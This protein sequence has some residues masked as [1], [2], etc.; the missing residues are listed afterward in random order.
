MKKRDLKIMTEPCAIV[1]AGGTGSRLQPVTIPVS[2]HLLPVYDKPMLHYALSNFFIAGIRSILVIG[3]NRDLPHYYALYGDGSAYGVEIKYLVQDTAKGIADAF[4]V[5][6]DFIQGRRVALALGDNMFYGAGLG[7]TLRECL[8]NY[9]GAT[10]LVSAVSDARRFGVLQLDELK[11]PIGIEEKPLVPK[12]NLAITGL[13]FFDDTV[14]GKAKA[15][16]PSERGELEITSILEAYL[17]EKRL[18]YKNLGRGVAWFDMGT[19]DSLLD[20]SNFVKSVQSRLGVQIGCLEEIAFRNGWISYDDLRA[21]CQRH[22]N[23][24]YFSYLNSLME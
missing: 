10:L 22:E 3:C 14:V 23:S 19:P 20:A 17:K 7:L 1:L 8:C 18:S 21:V 2:K 5:G 9:D 6:E 15:V 4:V 13:Y 24:Q 11:N 12:S 16:V